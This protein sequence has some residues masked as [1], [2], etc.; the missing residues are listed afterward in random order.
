MTASS[1]AVLRSRFLTFAASAGLSF[2]SSLTFAVDARAEAPSTA[3]RDDFPGALGVGVT[4]A[5]VIAAIRGDG[6]AH[7]PYFGLAVAPSYRFSPRFSLALRASLV[8]GPETATS[9]GLAGAGGDLDVKRRMLA[10]VLEARRHVVLGSTSEWWF[11]GGA[12]LAD[13]IWIVNDAHPSHHA[14]PLVGVATGIDF[15]SAHEMSI[16]FVA[17]GDLMAFGKAAADGDPAPAGLKTAAYGGLV[18][19]LY[20]PSDR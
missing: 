16:G 9:N 2:A 20:F 5:P 18:I 3:A 4:A 13:G 19:G 6:N 8:W 11:G 14:A 10:V 15:Y 17:R 12:G 7:D 1:D